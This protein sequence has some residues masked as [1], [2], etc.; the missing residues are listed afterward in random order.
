VTR[1]ELEKQIAAVSKDIDI[2]NNKIV[3]VIELA[4]E[5]DRLREDQNVRSFAAISRPVLSG[6]TRKPQR[7]VCFQRQNKRPPQRT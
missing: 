5:R 1:E 2:L 7:G 6:K 3:E 4:K